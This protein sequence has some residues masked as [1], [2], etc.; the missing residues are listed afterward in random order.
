MQ[1]L[2]VHKKAIPVGSINSTGMQATISPSFMC[3]IRFRDY[4]FKD[5]LGWKDLNCNVGAIDFNTKSSEERQK[6]W[7]DRSGCSG[8]TCSMSITPA[9]SPTS[10]V[11][12]STQRH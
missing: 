6:D 4:F 2:L 7:P 5:E 10:S 1:N 8:S 9:D 12:I 3:A 11:E